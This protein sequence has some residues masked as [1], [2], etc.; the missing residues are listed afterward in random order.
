MVLAISILRI[1]GIAVLSVAGIAAFL[2]L[3]PVTYELDADL[4]QRHANLRIRWLFGLIRFRLEYGAR[5]S[6][7]LF[8]FFRKIDFT[9]PEQKERRRK[10]KA[11]KAA[12]KAEK[13]RKKKQR[14]AKKAEARRRKQRRAY[15]KKKAK[16]RPASEQDSGFEP[17]IVHE[18]EN[19]PSEESTP[20]SEEKK[21]G[22]SDLL[23]SIRR[24]GK[25]IS[26]VSEHEILSLVFPKLQ[27]F[28]R[29]IRPR[30]LRGEL[31][32]GMEDPSQTGQILGILALLPFF[33]ET[34]FRVIPDF[35]TEHSYCSGNV[36]LGG[37]MCLIH[38]VVLVIRIIKEKKIRRWF[39]AQR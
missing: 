2:L 39:R 20:S 6:A 17:N 12:K 3:L 36:Y 29:R 1:A 28:L 19:L 18:Q 21:G 15:E 34:E 22:W 16:H 14:A 33:Y 35:E 30:A 8:L 38:A 11:L 5:L 10:K 24:I 13:S 25:M 27:I 32:F 37:H 4:E 26:S 31:R 23:Q 7:V 9:D